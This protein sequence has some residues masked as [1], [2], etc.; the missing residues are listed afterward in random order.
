MVINIA[1]DFGTC[2]TVISYLNSDC[3]INHIHD[4]IAA[5]ILIPSTLYFNF[6]EINEDIN[7]NVNKFELGKHYY[8]GT[9]A[10]EQYNNFKNGSL[11]FYQFKRFLGITSDNNFLKKFDNDYL[12]DSDGIYFNIIK[13]KIKI[14]II[15]LIKLYFI[16]LKDLIMNAN[17]LEKNDKNIDIV[18]TTPAYFHDLQRLQFKQGVEMAGFNV[19]KMYNEPTAASIYYIHTY[20]NGDKSDKGEDSDKGD[21]GS[22]GVGSKRFIVYDLGGG[23]IDTTVIEYHYNDNTC[24]ILDIDGNNSLGGIDIDNIIIENIYLKYNIDSKNIKNKS[25]IRKCAE[26]IKI[27]LTYMEK[28]NTILENIVMNNGDIKDVLKIDYTKHAFNNLVNEIINTM[29]EPVIKMSNLYNIN[30][31]I[32]I[33]GPTQ[34]PLL[35]KKIKIHLL[36]TFGTE[37]DSNNVDNIG[38]GTTL[39]KTIVADGA[40]YNY[41]SKITLL[42]ILPMNIGISKDDNNML[43]MIKKNS[44]IPISCEKVF[45]TSHDCQRYIDIT[46][47]EG[48]E[49]DCTYNHIIGK[50]KLVGIPPLKKGAILINLLFKININGIL[51]ISISGFKNPYND[52]IKNFDYKL[53]ENIKL[54]SSYMAKELLK[55]IILSKMS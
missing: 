12:I 42:D 5:T 3:I 18:I 28:Y 53:C 22:G 49:N 55:K 26:D 31:I 36:N 17:I 41:E 34:I 37:G 19:I 2:N 30:N 7:V 4:N 43:I 8:I 23:T 13:G 21:K 39:Y 52:D 25:K 35:Q 32:F 38:H 48:I 11:Y 29:I 1:I 46:I 50:Y 20:K 15:E 16:G 6:D 54:I 45:T 51:N 47:Y 27:N 33:G 40:C 14:S 10:N 24:E 44:K 9:V